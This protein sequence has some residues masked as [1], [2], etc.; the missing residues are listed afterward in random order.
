VERGA[1]IHY[2]KASNSEAGDNFG[3]TCCY[4]G[5]VALDGDTLVVGVPFE[6]SSATGVNGDQTNN[7]AQYAGA[8][9]VFV[10]SG[11]TWVQQAYLKASNT[12]EYQYFGET[13]AISGDT[14]VVGAAHESSSGVGINGSQSGFAQNSG[15]VYV[16]VRSGSTW[17]QQAYIKASNAGAL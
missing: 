3:G 16:F 12:A 11:S 5:M 7:A 13:V 10:R 8:A 15:A 14:I 6:R 1:D 17:T 4:F 2:L 9:Y